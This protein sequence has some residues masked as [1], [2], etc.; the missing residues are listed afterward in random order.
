M[1]WEE[2]FAE[3]KSIYAEGIAAA[4]RSQRFIK[5]LHQELESIPF[6]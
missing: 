5:R 1:T 3:M 2:T 6:N 4:V